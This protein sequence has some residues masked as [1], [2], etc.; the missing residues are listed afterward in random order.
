MYIFSLN[1]IKEKWVDTGFQK[2]FKN[3]GWMFASRI[4]CMIISFFTTTFIARKLGPENFG[5]L[6]YALSFVSIFSILSTLGIDSILYRDLIKNPDKKNKYLGSAFIIKLLA[7]FFTI[8]LVFISTFFFAQDDISKTLILILSGTFLFNTFQ[9]ISYEF[10]ARAKSKYPSI[11]SFLVTLILNILKILVILSGK[12]VIYLAFILLLESILYAVFYWFIYEKKLKEK[13][14][15]WK[16]DKQIAITLLKDSWPLMFTS[17][18][19]LVYSRIDQILIKNMIGASSVGIYSA[20]VTI[21]EVWYF[22]P[23]IIV[24]SL[25]PAIVNAKKTSEELYYT[26]LKKLFYTLLILAIVIALPITIFA[27]FIIKILYGQAFMKSVIILQ[28]YVW[29]CIGTFLTYL[30]YNYLIIENYRKS[31][32]LLSFIPM[33]INVVLNIL[34]IPKYGIVGS[35]YA[36]LISYSLG[37]FIMLFFRKTRQDFSKIIFSK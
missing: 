23:G 19:V 33:V 10:Q 9:I 26:R 18:F 7:G 17:A 34:W 11:I 30:I 25:F 35:A 6:S 20:G 37:P 8:I 12:G 3:T 14:S 1:Y 5:Q 15:E 2:Y 24:F 27:P 29:A 21:A 4:L 36:T 28:I 22:I 31:I 32:F 13:I 16:F